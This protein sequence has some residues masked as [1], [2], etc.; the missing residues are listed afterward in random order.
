MMIAIDFDDTLHL[1]SQPVPG[2]RMGPPI[3]GAKEALLQLKREGHTIVVHTVWSLDRQPVIREWLRFYGI[4][5]D[6]ITNIKPEA[7][8]FVDDRAVRFINW[9]RALREIHERQV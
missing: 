8:L 5:F 4:P 1:T 7:D 2:K 3:K 6:S 9:E